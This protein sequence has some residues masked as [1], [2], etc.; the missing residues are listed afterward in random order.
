[1]YP[2]RS[3]SGQ[4]VVTGRCRPFSPPALQLRSFLPHIGLSIPTARR[5]CIECCYIAL[6]CFPLIVD[7]KARK[8]KSL[9]TRNHSVRLEP[10]GLILVGA[11]TTYHATGDAGIV[12]LFNSTFFAKKYCENDGDLFAE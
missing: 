3:S 4:A 9:R 8:K 7:F 10:T 12:L 1:M 2:R 5:I 11:R 6:S